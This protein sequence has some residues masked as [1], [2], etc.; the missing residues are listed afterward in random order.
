M[1]V[2][3]IGVRETKDDS[4]I[5]IAVFAKKQKASASKHCENIYFLRLIA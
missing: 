3:L 1:L 2:A 5:A 4:E